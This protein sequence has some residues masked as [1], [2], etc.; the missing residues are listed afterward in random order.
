MNTSSFHKIFT[1][2]CLFFVLFYSTTSFSLFDAQLFAGRSWYSSETDGNRNGAA[3]NVVGLAGHVDPLPLIPVSFG[4]MLTKTDPLARDQVDGIDSDSIISIGIDVMGWLP[5]VPV[6]T[7]YGRF[8]VLVYGKTGYKSKDPDTKV[9]FDAGEGHIFS[10]GIKYS[11]LPLF[12]LFAELGKGITLTKITECKIGENS[13]LNDN[14]DNKRA[15]NHDRL[16]LGIQT[17]I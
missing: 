4:L 13:C 6:I 5:F 2:S 17:G 12:D 16:L 14:L 15:A 8:T 11:I 7:P 10:L 3:H 9:E 1:N